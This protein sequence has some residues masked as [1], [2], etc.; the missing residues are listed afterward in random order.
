MSFLS[1]KKNWEGFAKKDPLWAICTNP[2]KKDGKWNQD[3]FFDMGKTEVDSIIQMLQ[4]KKYFSNEHA[5]CLD[6]GCGV[7]RLSRALSAHFDQVIGLDVSSTMIAKAKELNDLSTEKLSFVHNEQNDL[8]IFEDNSFDFIFTTIVLQHIPKPASVNYINEFA[9]I[10]KP[11]GLI[12]FQLPVADLRKLTFVQKVRSSIKIRER[13]A[14]IGIGSGF[15]ME[16]HV[17]GE[18]EI[19]TI[20]DKA[21]CQILEAI[22]TNHTDPAFNGRIDY[23]LESNKN[24]GYLSKLFVIRKK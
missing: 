20:T 13:L 11:N 18:E 7:G 21:S 3:E 22:S 12:I 1:T 5:S 9:R 8:S 24:F 15:Q 14:L 19:K 4:Q 17:I 23:E 6:F 2:T 10:C 16:M